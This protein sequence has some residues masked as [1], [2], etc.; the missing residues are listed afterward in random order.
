MPDTNEYENQPVTRA[1]LNE[2]FIVLKAQIV[3]EV[4]DSLEATE[5]KLLTAFY[6]WA[7]QNDIKLRALRQHVDDSFLKTSA[8]IT[9]LAEQG[10]RT[11]E[12]LAQLAERVTE[13]AERVTELAEVGMHTDERLNALIN[14]VDGVVRG[15]Q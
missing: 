4:T 7:R 5:T 11:D 3:E 10:K 6:P 14:V 13:L 15:K 12:R 1:G 9:A 8:A 2:A